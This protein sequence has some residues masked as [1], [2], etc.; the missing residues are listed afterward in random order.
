[1]YTCILHPIVIY[2]KDS[3]GHLKYESVCIILD[4]NLHDKNFVYQVQNKVIEHIKEKHPEITKPYYFSD[5]CSVQCKNYK[6]SK[7][8]PSPK[9]F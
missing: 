8:M 3:E 6:K 1:M 9:M 4:Y 2:F 7:L 5:G